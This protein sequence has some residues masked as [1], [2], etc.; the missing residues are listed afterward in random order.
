MGEQP[1]GGL[2]RHAGGLELR[3]QSGR[4]ALA[5][6][7]RLLRDPDGL[8]GHA[9][10]RLGLG[11]ARGGQLAGALAGVGRDAVLDRGVLA[12]AEDAHDGQQQDEQP[13]ARS[14]DA[15]EH[16]VLG[17]LQPGRLDRHELG[18]VDLRLLARGRGDRDE[19]GVG[20][21][22]AV[23]V[24]GH[25]QGALGDAVVLRQGRGD[26]DLPS[27]RVGLGGEDLGERLRVRADDAAVA[28]VGDLLEQGL[29]VG[30]ERQGDH[31]DLDVAVVD[32]LGDRLDVGAGGVA[33]VG[34]QEQATGSLGAGR[35][36]GLQQSVVEVRGLAQLESVDD[37]R[38]RLRGRARGPGPRSPRSRR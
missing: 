29:V 25:R 30:G 37:L 5:A 16:L 34:Q 24:D 9:L 13:E 20:V 19:G 3:S 2:D 14:A 27:Q 6:L 22:L 8:R 10:L 21:G 28:G 32:A 33:P 23:G 36:H 35:L 1:L 18:P 15:E 31:V 12:A 17:D 26:Q 4:E 11:G 7:Q 38:R